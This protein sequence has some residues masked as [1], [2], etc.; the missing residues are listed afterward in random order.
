MGIT[1]LPFKPLSGPPR[2]Q[3][4]G[5]FL[6][7][8]GLCLL[9]LGLVAPTAVIMIFD[10]DYDETLAF[11]VA[12]P[13]VVGIYGGA[14][15]IGWG[16]RL[17]AFPAEQQLVSDQRS[18]VLFLRSFDDDDLLDP[19]PRMIPLGDMFPRR[20]EESLAK[21][22]EKIGP[23]ISI[24]RPGNKLSMLGGFRLF[25]S[26]QNWKEAVEHL[27]KHSAAVV[28]MVGRT[29][30]LWWEI[31]SSLKSV[32][33]QRLLFFFPFVEEPKRRQSL[34]QRFFGFRPAQVPL[35]K[36]AYIRMEEERQ[37]R[38]QL[39]RERAQPLLAAELPPELGS[40]QFIDIDS[41]GQIR[42]LPTFRPWWHLLTF[43]TPSVGK[44]IVNMQ[45][46]LQPF[47][48]KLT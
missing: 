26:D 2:R 42:V 10:M 36:R 23:M 1:P 8:L 43:A 38:Y 39:F 34:M 37:V 3:H 14:Q 18:P 6:I 22:L 11:V 47:T 12:I 32:P 30:G 29:E 35:S 41:T 21:P 46:T 9:I 7:V 5:L 45:R 28:L 31:E 40:S 17:R 44:M 16:R 24:G 13:F 27:R 4:L 20:Y 25:V 48:W 19:T 33:H 15:L